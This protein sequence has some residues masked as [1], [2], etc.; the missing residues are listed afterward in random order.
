MTMEPSDVGPKYGGHLPVTEVDRG[1]AMTLLEAA[2]AHGYLSADEYENRA[3]AI[4]SAAIRDD[5]R[6]ATRDLENVTY[7]PGAVW[8]PALAGAKDSLLKVGFFSG[9]SLEG[10]W[11]APPVLRCVGTFG[12]V[13][14]DLTDAVWTSD[15]IVIDA[16]AV[17]GGVRVKVPAGVEVVDQTFAIFGG[18]SVRGAS[19]GNRRV[20]VKGVAAFG[21][22]KVKGP[23]AEAF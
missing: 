2:R 7:R 13:Y 21:G 10:R 11:N 3:V 12:G 14:V 18:T 15:E 17:F 5:L 1:D 8:V 19:S 20:I 23:R 6:L 9:T 22:I 4:R 16:Y